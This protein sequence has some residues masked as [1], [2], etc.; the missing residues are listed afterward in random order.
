[1]LQLSNSLI[2]SL[3]SLFVSNTGLRDSGEQEG[4]GI[5]GTRVVSKQNIATDVDAIPIANINQSVS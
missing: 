3:T 1:M 4:L 2:S 5:Y